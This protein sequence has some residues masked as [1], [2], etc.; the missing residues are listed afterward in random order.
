MTQPSR[1]IYLPPGLVPGNQPQSA[2]PG[3]LPSGIPFDR[4]FFEQV[5]PQAIAGFCSQ[6]QCE[7]PLVEIATVDGM[8]H[9]VNGISGVADA[10]VALRTSVPEHEHPVQAFI[11][12]QTIF[13]IEIHPETDGR[14]NHLGFDTSAEAPQPTAYSSALPAVAAKAGKS[15]RATGKK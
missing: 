5:L 14:R 9:Y 2:H 13:R 7:V 12:Y 11:P 15:G 8:T 1:V 6:T 3:P 10:W 4:A